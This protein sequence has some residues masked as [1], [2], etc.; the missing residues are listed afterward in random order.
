[1]ETK[2]PFQGFE[3]S[4]TRFGGWEWGGYSR[5]IDP[6]SMYQEDPQNIPIAESTKRTLE[7][8][9][10]IL[11]AEQVQCFSSLWKAF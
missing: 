9:W 10:P 1:M 4:I 6:D 5:Q 2:L 7:Q 11:W 8:H 3:E